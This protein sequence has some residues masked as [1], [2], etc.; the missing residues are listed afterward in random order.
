MQRRAIHAEQEASEANKQILRLKKK[1]EEEI[2]RLNHLQ[3]EPHLPRD[4]SEPT[5]DNTDTGDD[6]W[7]E[8]FASFYSTKEDDLPK[9]GESSSWFSGYDRCNV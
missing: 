7:K 4:T 1:H 8:E 3:E 6:R 5:Y 9:F 2:N